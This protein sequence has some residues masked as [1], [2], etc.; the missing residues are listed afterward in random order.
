MLLAIVTCP[1][2]SWFWS[3]SD[4]AVGHRRR[5]TKRDL[6]RLASQSGLEPAGS[7]YFMFLLSPLLVLS[8]FLRPHAETLD[9]KDLQDTIRRTY[10]IPTAIVDELLA[11]AL[12]VETPVGLWVPFPWGTSVHGVFRGRA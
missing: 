9:G 1:A 6:A 7:A 12:A 10:R 2:F 11:L 4:R 5:C 8:R 3:Y